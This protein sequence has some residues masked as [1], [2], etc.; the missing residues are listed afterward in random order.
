MALENT[1]FDSSND[2][3]QFLEKFKEQALSSKPEDSFYQAS[4]PSQPVKPADRSFEKLEKKIQE[5][6]EKFEVSATQ[7]QLILNELAHT[8]EEMSRQKSRDAFLDNISHTIAS[9]K[10]SVE[11]LSRAQQ[12]QNFYQG[13][14]FQRSFDPVPS[15]PVNPYLP[16]AE[17]VLHA[18]N[19]R[20]EQELADKDKTIAEKDKELSEKEKVFSS[21]RQKASQLKAV[22]SALDREIK[23]VQAEKLDALKRSAEQAKEILSLREQLTAAEERFKSFNFEGRI[24]SIRQEYEQKVAHLETQLKEISNTC[25]KQVEEIESL[26]AENTKLHQAAQERDSLQVRLQEANAQIEELKMEMVVLEKSSSTAS[27]TQLASYKEQLATL[28]AQRDRLAVELEQSKTAYEALKQ[29]KELLEKNF[30]ELLAKIENNEVVINQLKEQIAVL[31]QQNDTLTHANKELQA[32]TTSLT[33][34]NTALTAQT[35]QLDADKAKLSQYASHLNQEK[36]ILEQTNKTL[37]QENQQLR[38][39][40]AAVLAA[41]L[42]KQKEEQKKSVSA[43]QP[44]AEQPVTVAKAAAEVA[45]PKPAT[46]PKPAAQPKQA[47]AQAA[48]PKQAQTPAQAQP[49]ATQA[50]TQPKQEATQAQAK[51]TTE[52]DLPEIKVADPIPQPEFDDGEDFLEKTDTFI[53]R[54]KWS[55]FHE[56]K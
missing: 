4:T 14:S 27:Q 40:S 22:N 18:E 56:D 36:H 5:L 7:N 49:Q 17:E 19:L 52:A 25:M 10:M 1:N 53:G 29:E 16:T 30:K 54:I 31:G 15:A 3:A 33:A 41:H 21:L 6:E 9:L 35:R 51:V 20:H 8:R 44:R 42:V 32:Q 38:N 43:Q 12:A 26:K 45:Q 47:Q 55:V 23:K 24:I 2:I 39:Q 37:A 34:Q 46:Q 48:Q 50:Q 13:P 11:N 28:S